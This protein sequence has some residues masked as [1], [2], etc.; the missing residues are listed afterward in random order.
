M[1][2]QK[3][4]NGDKSDLLLNPFLSKGWTLQERKIAQVTINLVNYEITSLV[5]VW[6]EVNKRAR[7]YCLPICGS[8]IVGVVPLQAIL[9]VADYYIRTEN[10]LILEE[11]LKVQYVISKLGLS[12]LNEFKPREKIIEYILEDNNKSE[13][14]VNLSVRAFVEQV[15]SREPVP[16]GGSVSA[17]VCSLACALVTMVGRISSGKKKFECNDSL[18]KQLLPAFYNASQRFLT[19]VDL[20]AEA[21]AKIMNANRLPESNLNESD[22]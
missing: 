5:Q 1:Q 21:Y 10:L 7:K 14:L 4:P 6:E 3:K 17:L 15:S 13:K 2:Q 16:G 22:M 8:E 18:V 20:D 9:D 19:F 11:E 12:F